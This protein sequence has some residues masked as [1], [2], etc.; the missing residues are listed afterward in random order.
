MKVTRAQVAENRRSILEAAARRFREHGFEGVTVAEIMGDAK[1]THGA[2]YRHFASKEELIAKSFEHVLE[3]VKENSPTDLV[4]YANAY[5]TPA[6]RDDASNACLFSTLGTEI[7]RSTPE[8]RRVMTASMSDQLRTLTLT[9][10]GKTA[11][12]R[13]RAAIAAWSAM[14]GAVMLARIAD[15]PA[16]SE[17][18]LAETRK[19]LGGH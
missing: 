17:E 5:L 18:I 10:P 9:A 6:H 19:V 15:D 16:L 1:L 12:E 7:A 4:E 8:T 2:F 13:R 14:V 11:R 3:A